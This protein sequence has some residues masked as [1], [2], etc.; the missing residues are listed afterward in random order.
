MTWSASSTRD[1]SEPDG[2]LDPAA[3]FVPVDLPESAQ[4]LLIAGER[5]KFL[6]R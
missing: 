1:Q 5:L 2:Y 4:R 6:V 3:T